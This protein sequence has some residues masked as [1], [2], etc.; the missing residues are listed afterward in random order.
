MSGK[1]NLIEHFI[2]IQA[3]FILSAG[4]L[5]YAAY[6]YLHAG[7]HVTFKVAACLIMSIAYLIYGLY[8]RKKKSKS[9]H[10]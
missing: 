8:T 7:N 6:C 4:F 3:K 5:A 2:S 9:V 1:R 10:T